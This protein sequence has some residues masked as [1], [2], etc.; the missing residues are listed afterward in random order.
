MKLFAFLR[1]NKFILVV[2]I[3]IVALVIY[4]M[5]NVYLTSSA[6]FDRSSYFEI[7]E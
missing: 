1:K 7:I 5:Y 4:E 6:S 3:F 2:S